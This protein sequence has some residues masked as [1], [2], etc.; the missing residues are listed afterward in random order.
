LQAKAGAST[1]IPCISA[2]RHCPSR[3][4]FTRSLPADCYDLYYI[5]QGRKSKMLN[6]MADFRL[7]QQISDFNAIL[8][9]FAIT[10]IHQS[11][12]T[13]SPSFP[14]A[15]QLFLRQYPSLFRPAL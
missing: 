10:R 11:L 9:P 13:P 14:T 2:I 7:R 6:E 5:G 4:T 12:F 8:V 15:S 1:R 3:R